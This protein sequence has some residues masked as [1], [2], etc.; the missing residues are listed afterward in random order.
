MKGPRRSHW[1]P[2]V[3][4]WGPSNAGAA[5]AHAGGGGSG[6][7]GT[8]GSAMAGSGSGVTSQEWHA[9]DTE[10]AGDTFC[11]TVL[12][13]VSHA[14]GMRAVAC[15]QWQWEWQGLSIGREATPCHLCCLLC[16]VAERRCVGGPEAVSI[17]K[18]YRP[19]P[20][21]TM[22][23]SNRQLPGKHIGA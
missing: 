18:T 20:T 5:T 7:A 6:T 21:S 8:S 19:L 4:P 1:H 22:E 3:D 16:T 11:T 23:H 14:S 15:R 2:S 12:L 10:H 17:I 13:I 9:G